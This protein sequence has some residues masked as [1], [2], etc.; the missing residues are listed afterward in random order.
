MESTAAVILDCVQQ[1]I[2]SSQEPPTRGGDFEKLFQM[3]EDLGPA[4]KDFML[5]I[6][7]PVLTRENIFEDFD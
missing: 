1:P 6:D 5:W 2:P 3:L 7:E 4:P